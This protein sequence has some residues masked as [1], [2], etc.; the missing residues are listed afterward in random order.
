MSRKWKA[1]YGLFNILDLNIAFDVLNLHLNA[2]DEVANRSAFTN[3]FFEGGGRPPF[4]LLGTF[5][6][7]QKILGV[8]LHN[9]LESDAQFIRFDPLL[10]V[11]QYGWVAHLFSRLYQH[12]LCTGTLWTLRFL[13]LWLRLL[14]S[15]VLPG[16]KLHPLLFLRGGF[17]PLHLRLLGCSVLRAH[18]LL[19][20]PFPQVRRTAH[21][22]FWGCL[23]AL[24]PNALNTLDS[25]FFHL[26][27]TCLSHLVFKWSGPALRVFSILAQLL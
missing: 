25:R 10:Q 24:I 3:N 15:V 13:R 17:R 23:T 7:N 9:S 12:H 2:R 22:K 11:L 19:S 21:H 20:R 26:S 5:K 16:W 6:L 14:L 8:R 18:G 1:F 4:I 27:T